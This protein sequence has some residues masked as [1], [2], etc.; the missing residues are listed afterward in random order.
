MDTACIVTTPS[1]PHG[2]YLI[3]NAASC[4]GDGLVRA[5]GAAL[6]AG[7]RLVQYRDKAPLSE[8]QLA[9]A[10]AL[11]RVTRDHGALLLI[12][13]RVDLALM[14]EA[15][16]VHL[17]QDDLPIDAARKL[18]PP[19]AVVGLS[20]HTL[21]EARAAWQAGADYIGFGDVFGT[22]S[23]A[24]VVPPRGTD[25]LARICAGVSI[26]VYA[27]G[28]VTAANLAAVKAAGAA[29]GALIGAVL[30]ADDPGRA[31]AELN[32]IWQK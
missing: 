28:G 19:G 24:D 21:A 9:T 15:D 7:V 32:A 16:G 25:M 17:G 5:V 14:C 26:P 8:A 27:I 20:T 13:D 30:K 31:A 6:Q 12:N 4:D 22:T 3:A 2:V 1:L 29:G 18:L 11:R 10:T 23:K